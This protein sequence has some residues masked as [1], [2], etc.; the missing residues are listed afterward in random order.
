MSTDSVTT[1]LLVRPVRRLL[2][3]LTGV[4]SRR[5][6]QLVFGASVVGYLLVYLVAVGDLGW[7][8]NPGTVSISVVDAPLPRLFESTGPF[9]YEP[10][11]LIE[12]WVIEYLFAPLTAAI[13]L[14]IA[15]LVGLN[16]ALAYGAWRQPA[17]CGVPNS[18]GAD[19]MAGVV[20]GLPA[21]LSGTVCCGPAILLVVG[22]QAT[23][24]LLAVFQWLLPAAVV[25][26]IGSLFVVS[27][28]V[29][30]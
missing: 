20:A 25:L 19:G 16:F 8:L 12:L 28:R 30:L 9:Q 15:V 26:L 11:A 17:A 29:R 1:R 21:L 3:A 7:A 23:A 24:G 14:G 22:V 27:R 6:G 2:R 10:I 13:G 5:D 18:G 4:L